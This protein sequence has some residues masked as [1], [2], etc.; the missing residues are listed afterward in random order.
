MV[1]L[2]TVFFFKPKKPLMIISTVFL[3][4]IFL[5][6]FFMSAFD[7][8]SILTHLDKGDYTTINFALPSSYH[9]H[10]ITGLIFDEFNFLV[11]NTVVF[12]LIIVQI[13]RSFKA[14]KTAEPTVSLYT[15]PSAPIQQPAYQQPIAPV[16][17]TYQQPVYQQPVQPMYQQPVTPVGQ[18]Q[19]SD[20]EKLANFKKLLDEGII[21]QEQYDE[22]E[23]EILFG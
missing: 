5:A 10:F 3:T 17:P 12:S 14:V 8:I 7:I 1:V 19:V 11:V 6:L 22:K 20:D 9:Y 15:Q 4:V 23:R 16:Q 18:K 13:F 2:I 21:T